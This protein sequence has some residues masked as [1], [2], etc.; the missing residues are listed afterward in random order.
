MHFWYITETDEEETAF[1]VDHLRG[2]FDVE[3]DTIILRNG[4]RFGRD[5]KELETKLG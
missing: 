1:M 5:L 4:A 2:F 3:F